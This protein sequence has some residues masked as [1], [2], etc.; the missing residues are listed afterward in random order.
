MAVVELKH[1]MVLLNCFKIALL[2]LL[3]D[4]LLFSRRSVLELSVVKFFWFDKLH[5]EICSLLVLNKLLL[6][7]ILIV[8]KQERVLEN[9]WIEVSVYSKQ[10][11]LIDISPFK[12][13]IGVNLQQTNKKLL[14]LKRDLNARRKVQ[15]ASRLQLYFCF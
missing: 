4:H 2:I 10:L 15:S 12:P 3:S 8:S 13:L 6:D 1:L 14:A 7:I 5:F 11:V 9:V